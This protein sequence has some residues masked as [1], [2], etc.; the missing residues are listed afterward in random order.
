MISMDRVN[1]YGMTWGEWFA[2]T[3]WR[4]VNARQLDRMLSDWR[5]GG[6]PTEWRSL[7]QDADYD[8]FNPNTRNTWYI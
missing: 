6:D 8:R 7:L 1:E 3:F 5:Q 4:S 2:A